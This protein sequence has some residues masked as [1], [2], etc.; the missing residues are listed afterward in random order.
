MNDEAK[1]CSA[2]DEI[3]KSLAALE[4]SRR[5]RIISKIVMAA[6]GSI[7]WVGGVLTAGQAYADQTFQ[8]KIDNL[9]R[10]WLEEHRARFLDL[11]RTLSE[12]IERL[13]DLGEEI[14]ERIESEAYLTLVRK[15]FRNWDQ[16]D[17]DQKR[18]YIQRLITNA[19]AAKLCHDDLVRLFLDWLDQYHEAHFLVIK[20]IYQ[21]PGITRYSIWAKIH[22]AFPREDSSEADLFRLLIHD[23]SIGRV[24]RQHRETNYQGEFLKKPRAASRS[25]PGVLKSAFDDEEPY[26]LTELGK[27]FVHYVFTEV[28]KKLGANEQPA[29]EQTT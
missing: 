7:P 28:V 20:E 12:I 23:L 15:A 3:Q 22:G 24:I 21:S 16:A 29:A 6:L 8:T 11:S 1:I 19:G 26:E 9:Q 27:L 18:R 10:R 5:Q 4:P 25:S 2:E 17:T 13:G 14:D